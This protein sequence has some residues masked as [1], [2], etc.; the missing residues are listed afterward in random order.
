MSVRDRPVITLHQQS[1]VPSDSRCIYCQCVNCPIT[2]LIM[3][4]N[5]MVDIVYLVDFVLQN[6]FVNMWLVLYGLY[7]LRFHILTN[8][9]RVKSNVQQIN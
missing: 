5:I 4:N 6:V 7:G 2:W 1:C 3:A 8:L 9:I